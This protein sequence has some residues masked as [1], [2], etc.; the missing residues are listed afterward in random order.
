MKQLLVSTLLAA[1]VATVG[2]ATASAVSIGFNPAPPIPVLAG[3]SLSV[4]VVVSDLGSQ[5]VSAYDV[6][7]TYDPLLLLPVSV[8]FGNALGITGVETIEGAFDLFGILDVF[9]VSLLSDAE[10][11][12]LQ[13]GGP[14]TLFTMGFDVLED[15]DA[16]LAFVWDQFND[17]KGRDNR[18]IIPSAIPEPSTWLLMGLG[19]AGLWGGSRRMTRRG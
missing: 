7:V 18:V 2:A 11:D 4:D 16:D 12:T 5:I 15:G 8:V 19:L 9:E 13:A 1:G 3:G 10:L 17:V 6:D 14:L